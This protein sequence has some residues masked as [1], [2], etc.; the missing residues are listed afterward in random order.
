MSLNALTNRSYTHGLDGFKSILYEHIGRWRLARTHE[1]RLGVE[2]EVVDI[3]DQLLRFDKWAVDQVSP[4]M[5]LT[6]DDYNEPRTMY[7]YIILMNMVRVRS[8]SEAYIKY[9]NNQRTDLLELYGKIRRIKQKKATLDLWGGGADKY[10]ISESFFNMDSIGTKYINSPACDIDPVSGCLTLPLVASAEIK[11]VNITIGSG[12]NGFPGNSDV[13]VTTNNIN[14]RFIFDGEA[15]TWFEYE[16]QAG[17]LNLVLICELSKTEVLNQIDIE[18]V[19]LGSGINYSV[20]DITFSSSEKR[21]ATL[22]EMVSGEV[23]NDYFTVSSS[24]NDSYWSCRFLPVS[25]Q[26]VTVRLKQSSSQIGKALNPESREVNRRRY[27][28]AVRSIAF[29]KNEYSS[30]GAINSTE[31]AIIQGLYAAAMTTQIFPRHEKLFEVYADISFDGSETW[32]KDVYSLPESDS[33]TQILDGSASSAVWRFRIE[34]KDSAFPDVKS[35]TDDEVEFDIESKQ[36]SV[37]RRRSPIRMSLPER[38]VNHEVYVIQPKVGRRTKNR[39]DSIRLGSGRS[40]KRMRIPL[41]YSLYDMNLEPEQLHVYVNGNLW[42]RVDNTDATELAPSAVDGEY[43]LTPA[44]DALV[45]SSHLP[46]GAT[47][48]FRFDEEQV[49]WEEAADGYYATLSSPFDPDPQNINI[50][51]RPVYPVR[52]SKILPK[53]KK[54]INLNYK[55]I[56]YE[57]GG[58]QIDLVST[59]S[60]GF[61]SAASVADLSSAYTAGYIRYYLDSENGVL[62]LDRAIDDTHTVKIVFEHTQAEGT[63]RD[64][65]T[66]VTDGIIPTGI[67]VDKDALQ[68]TTYEDKSRSKRNKRMDPI[69]RKYKRR[70]IDFT[71]DPLPGGKATILTH[72][73]VVKGSV[74]VDSGVLDGKN[75]N[76]FPM[77][78][79][80]Y[81]DG[82]TEFLGLIPM[83]NEVTL[84]M[85]AGATGIVTFRLAAGASVYTDLGVLFGKTSVFDPAKKANSLSELQAI[86]AANI[87]GYFIDFTTG[88]VHVTVGSGG[89]LES[90]VAIKYSYYDPFF[91]SSNL[92]SVDYKR[93]IFFTSQIQKKSPRSSNI[94]YKT[95]KHTVAYDLATEIDRYKYD[96]ATNSVRVRTEGLLRINSIVKVVWGKAVE[97]PDFGA[98]RRY[99]SPIIQSVGVRFQ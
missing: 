56:V 88:D 52:V 18:P 7:R 74:V 2:W 10:I 66:V 19:N 91:D 12:S 58:D 73:Y 40:G 49:L 76:D 69:E 9:I 86:G 30:I 15:E 82:L 57:N 60:T 8:I 20:E 98:L 84:S 53:G 61:L 80:D 65:I 70:E 93:G 33:E 37:S 63:D 31:T 89:T 71:D 42:T 26:T 62:H 28:I 5:H 6:I 45:F 95:S 44:H 46:D 67:R 72:D 55:D 92:Y 23:D 4:K 43:H 16:G 79:V 35:L 29:R 39:K 34:R 17:P 68:L 97:G 11:P 24:E 27:A 38:P 85:K 81:V 90:D 87:G 22:K 77:T 99:F 59:G 21:V 41:G 78:E 51:G 96:S 14:P 1:E 50:A 64:K 75:S 3:F 83:E 94:S 13:A 54:R 47:V 25:C 36:R 48:R 32:A